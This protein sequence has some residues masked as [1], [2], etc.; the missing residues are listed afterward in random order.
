MNAK[1]QHS[2][3][4]L[5]QEIQ[6]HSEQAQHAF[7][8]VFSRVSRALYAID[9]IMHLIGNE[10]TAAKA[11]ESV[12][13]LIDRCSNDFREEIERYRKL[14]KDNGAPERV[15]FSNPLVTS[16]K[17]SSPYDSRYLA[18][19]TNLDELMSVTEVLRIAAIFDAKQKEA[20]L[21][22]QYAARQRVMNVGSRIIG[23]ANAAWQTADKAGKK[24]EATEAGAVEPA[25]DDSAENAPAT[26]PEAISLPAAD[27]PPPD[28]A[29]PSSEQESGIRETD[30]V[31]TGATKPTPAK[32]TRRRRA[33]A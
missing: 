15:K 32:S 1:R 5:E 13:T 21:E 23:L 33:A 3:P 28:Q 17:I 9:V 6:L 2:V 29:A 4:Y 31:D 12:N 11:G 16:V 22:F 27:S 18:L 10:K 7:R 25:A 24:Q 20:L 30:T 8:R 14:C 26:E 19:L